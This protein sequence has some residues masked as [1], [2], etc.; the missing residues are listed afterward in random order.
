MKE[1]IRILKDGTMDFCYFVEVK[2][3]KAERYS[4]AHYAVYYGHNI[5]G[6]ENKTATAVMMLDY[7]NRLIKNGKIIGLEEIAT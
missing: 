3:E 4:P 2:F 1:F 7:F 5:P 6:H